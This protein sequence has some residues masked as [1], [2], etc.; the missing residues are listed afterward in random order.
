MGKCL[1]Y[2]AEYDCCG[3]DSTIGG[4]YQRLVPC[5]K[6]ERF[7]PITNYVRIKAMSKEELAGMLGEFCYI[8]ETCEHCPVLGRC[9]GTYT[10]NAWLDW[11]NSEV[12]E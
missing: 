12:K 8:A 7:K 2:C 5:H 3:K 6:C 10:N 1:Y 11:L 4:R 9:P